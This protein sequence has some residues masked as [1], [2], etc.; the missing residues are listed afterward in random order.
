MELN[1]GMSEWNKNVDNYNG[2]NFESHA[3][4][5]ERLSTVSSPF[6]VNSKILWD[7]L[8]YRLI[9]LLG[10][11]PTKQS[12]LLISKRVEQFAYF[13]R[14]Q[15]N[16][17]KMTDLHQIWLQPPSFQLKFEV[18]EDMVRRDECNHLIS[19]W[20]W[21][22]ISLENTESGKWKYK[23]CIKILSTFLKLVK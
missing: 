6:M 22:N 11:V 3:A 18:G 21:R 14:I 7:Q 15:P 1:I 4:P 23:I 16:C 13:C 19:V 10:I 20:E 8:G 5:A 9:L 17:S 12:E 2:R